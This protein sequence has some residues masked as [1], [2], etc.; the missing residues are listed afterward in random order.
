MA[1]EKKKVVIFDS[2]GVLLDTVKLVEST[3]PWLAK[4]R[5]KPKLYNLMR[6]LVILY[7]ADRICDG[8]LADLPD[9]KATIECIDKMV[10]DKF[11]VTKRPFVFGVKKRLMRQLD[12]V[13]GEGVF[14]PK[15]VYSSF[16]SKN[17]A[18]VI[19]RKILEPEMVGIMLDDNINNLYDMPE[20]I[21]AVLM[22]CESLSRLTQLVSEL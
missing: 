2:D 21:M 22:D 3:A 5:E 16:F 18:D 6:E 11:V 15:N 14:K 19:R 13:Y 8:K 4:L 9:G 7:C 10:D 17:K 12:Y 1:S 20:E